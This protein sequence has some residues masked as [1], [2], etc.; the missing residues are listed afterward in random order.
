[1]SDGT[2]RCFMACASG[3]PAALLVHGALEADT[4]APAAANLRA[5]LGRWQ[6]PALGR[7][8]TTREARYG[9]LM[10][11]YD[12]VDGELYQQY[13]AAVTPLLVKHGAE[14]LTAAHGVNAVEGAAR[15]SNIVLKFASQLL[16]DATESGTALIAPEFVMP[17]A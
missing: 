5:A 14:V 2:N 15:T 7:A 17:E 12:V 16:L 10:F 11:S 1:M 13:V 6:V 3:G 4:P 9:R 8:A